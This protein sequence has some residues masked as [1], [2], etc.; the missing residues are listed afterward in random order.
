MIILSFIPLFKKGVEGE[1]IDELILVSLLIPGLYCLLTNLLIR[2]MRKTNP[3]I[4]SGLM[5]N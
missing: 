3:D 4:L 2:T 5:I 1:F